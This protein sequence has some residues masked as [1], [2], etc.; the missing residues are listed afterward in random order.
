MTRR[1]LI[2][3]LGWLGV[4]AAGCAPARDPNL[5]AI[6]FTRSH[7]QQDEEALP[8][9]EGFLARSNLDMIRVHRQ[10]GPPIVLHAVRVAEGR[11]YGAYYDEGIPV[12]DVM[13]V[14]VPVYPPSS[15]TDQGGIMNV[16]SIL[17][18][19]PLGCR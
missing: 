7:W 5:S 14:D 19:F 16:L 10:G 18:C 13:A 12:A 15:Y 8:D 6:E 17:E 11:L 9:L 1:A 3:I 2:G 4:A